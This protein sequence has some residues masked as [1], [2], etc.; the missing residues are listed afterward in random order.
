MVNDAPVPP[1]LEPDAC[2]SNF[3]RW[4]TTANA[5]LSLSNTMPASPMLW[6]SAG[7]ASSARRVARPVLSRA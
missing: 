6:A 4:L 3:Q 2:G 1:E 5:R 7:K